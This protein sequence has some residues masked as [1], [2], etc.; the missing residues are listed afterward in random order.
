M[1]LAIF[2]EDLSKPLVETG[3]DSAVDAVQSITIPDDIFAVSFNEPLVHQVVTAYLSVARAG[4]RRQK[5]RADVRGGGAKPYR[6]KGTGRARVGTTRSPL[7]RGGGV[8]F[9]ARPK[10][11]IQKL[12][13]KMYRGALRSMVSELIR[14]GCLIA[15]PDF[16]M[17]SIKTREIASRLHGLGLMNVLIIT[18]Q[19]ENNLRLSVRNLRWADILDVH[20]LDPVS[21]IKHEKVLITVAA[22]RKLE[23][24]LR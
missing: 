1:E 4:T 20:K 14:Q 2:T 19:Q 11:Y 5:N 23:E 16:G 6:Q 7:W 17:S 21:L 22:L 18:E 24:R 8:T 3:D 15:V 12:N 13:K 9:A 10:R